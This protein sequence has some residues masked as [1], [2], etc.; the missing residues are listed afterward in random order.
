MLSFGMPTLIETHS[1]DECAQLAQRLNLRFIE[2]NMNL[3]Q[4][5]LPVLNAER[6]I[7]ASDRYCLSFTIHLD[8]NLNPA[9]FN[10]LVA[11]AYRHTV[12]ETIALARAV[13]IPIL[14]MHL[15]RGVYFTLPGRRVYLF[16]EYESGYLS[17][18]RSFRDECAQRIGA[19][20]IRICIENTD[21]FLPFQEKAVQLLL[22][23]PSFALTLDAGHSHT[24]GCTDESLFERHSHALAHMHLHDALSGCNHLPLGTGEADIGRYLSMAR[25]SGCRVVLETKT[26][27]G[28]CQSVAW[29][30]NHTP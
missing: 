16:G 8:E 20:N 5:Q 30:R 14:N 2:L 23:C 17:A 28:L 13:R 26:I 18:M 19:E 9:D 12:Y 4:Y 27:D 21:G 10:P 1:L 29:L 6:L 24:A 7:A 11:E 22:E 3:P 25:R 15:P